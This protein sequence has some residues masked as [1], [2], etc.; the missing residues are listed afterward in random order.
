MLRRVMLE[1]GG[2]DYDGTIRNISATGALVEG[3]WNVPSGT[4]FRIRLGGG[5][6]VG[7]TA[8]WCREDRM[9]VEFDTALPLD[10][11]GRVSL[12]PPRRRD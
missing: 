8:R 9:G 1:N 4:R 2:Q 6:E 5:L 10:E 3:L 11:T 7:A 12:S